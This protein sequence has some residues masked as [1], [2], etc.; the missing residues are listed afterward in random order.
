MRTPEDNNAHT[1]EQP[2]DPGLGLTPENGWG[3]LIFV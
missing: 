3:F 2:L 1:D